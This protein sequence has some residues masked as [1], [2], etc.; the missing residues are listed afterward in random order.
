[1]IRVNEFMMSRRLRRDRMGI[2]VAMVLMRGD[3]EAEISEW[4]VGGDV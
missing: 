2:G 1:M 3:N 4:V